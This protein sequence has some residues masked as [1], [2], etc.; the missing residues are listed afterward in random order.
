VPALTLGTAVTALRNEIEDR[1]DVTALTTNPPSHLSRL[2]PGIPVSGVIDGVNKRFRVRHY[3]V[4]TAATIADVIQVEDQAGNAF[5]VD[6]PTSDFLRGIIALTTAPASATS[7][8]VRF[9]YFSRWFFDAQLVEFLQRACEFVGV[10]AVPT[11]TTDPL[12]VGESQQPTALKFAAHLCAKMLSTKTAEFFDV[13]AGGKDASASEIPKMYKA[14]ADE[15]YTE[16]KE[17]LENPYT[18]QGRREAPALSITAYPSG[19][20]TPSR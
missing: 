1:V 12:G 5:L 15:L 16:A 20:Y 18:R 3:P 4:L 7:T 9:T 8:E 6:V 17:L 14:L 19:T 2:E 11:L 13:S 10:G